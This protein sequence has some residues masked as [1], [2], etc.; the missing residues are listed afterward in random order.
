M[1]HEEPRRVRS[2]SPQ[3]GLDPEVVFKVEGVIFGIPRSQL[4]V[5]EFFRDM[6]N[7]EHIGTPDEG[8]KEN[9]IV[10]D[11]VSLSQVT[12]FYKVINS[13]RFDPQPNLSLKQWS[14][15]LHLAT[16]WGFEH[17]R[18]YII[19]IL[20]SLAQDPLD[21]IQIADE[22]GLT[23]WL[24]PAYAKLCARDA[25]LTAEEGR[26][27]GFGRF[28]ALGWIRETELKQRHRPAASA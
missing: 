9:P 19:Q 12:S 13:R 20:D 2:A 4:L 22:C 26:R 24:H 14:E 28:A 16:S 5:S 23:E 8:T 1:A 7:S 17:L 15:A 25:P 18:T 11:A 10:L 27:L 3:I 21:R 6:L